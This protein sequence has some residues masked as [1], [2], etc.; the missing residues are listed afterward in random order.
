[1]TITVQKQ[2]AERLTDIEK[3]IRE[4]EFNL[5]S[6]NQSRNEILNRYFGEAELLP[7]EGD[8]QVASTPDWSEI[9]IVKK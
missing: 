3:K 1:M 9:I 7:M 6:L 8:F 2:D 5:V 4:I